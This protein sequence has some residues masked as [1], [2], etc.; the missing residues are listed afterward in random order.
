M[1]PRNKLFEELPAQLAPLV[2]A[3]SSILVG[4]SGGVDSVVLLHLLHRLAPRFSW[5][6]SAL[7]VHHGISP[8]ADAWADFCAGLC[9]NHAIPLHV[10]H[11]DI[12]PLRAHGIEAAAR[13]LRHAALARQACGFVALAHHADDQAETLLLQLLRGAGVKGA[14]AMPFIKRAGT[15]APSPLAVANDLAAVVGQPGQMASSSIREGWGEG[16]AYRS[17]LLRPLL[18]FSR[19]EIL[20]YAAAHGLRWIEDE[21]NADDSYPRNFLRHRLLPLL[22]EKFPACRDTLARSA[23]HFA[24]AS[25]LL[26]DLARLDASDLFPSPASGITSDLAALPSSRMASSSIGGVGGEGNELHLEVSR[27]QSLPQPRA[28]NLLRYFLHSIG[29]PMPQAVQLDDM[30]RQLC[31]ARADAAVCAAYGDWEVHRYQGRVYALRALGEF[32]RSFV[33]QWCGETGLDWPALNARLIFERTPG[34][35][36]G[37][38]KLQR[39]PVTLRLRQ[40]G[41]TLRPHP[42][43]ATRTLK[44]LLQERRVPPWQRDRLPLLYCGAELVCATGVAI[45]AEYRAAK[46]E[47]GISVYLLG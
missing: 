43:A 12:A 20:D 3:H 17:D 14:A 6:L 29:A 27:L 39:A 31:G 47:A 16:E 4:L 28:K 21:S 33:L 44:N 42:D 26:D 18:H 25:G 22:E 2:P 19:R 35:G 7:H 23:R 32:D 24:E 41:E 38:E 46:G 5:R 8:N 9:A 36:I 37:L 1:H 34:E 10:E 30:L 13:K 15:H 11:V 40:G 45:A